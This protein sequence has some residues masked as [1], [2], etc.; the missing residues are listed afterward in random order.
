MRH[1]I[2][3]QA[4]KYHICRITTCC[5]FGIRIDQ[6]PVAAARDCPFCFAFVELGEDICRLF[7]DKRKT[8][9]M[10]EAADRLHV[11]LEEIAIAVG[12]CPRLYWLSAYCCD[13]I[14][15]SRPAEQA[16]PAA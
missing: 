10:R 16:Q 15:I 12:G 4:A 9:H 1:V 11:S 8:I 3:E 14:G 2:G 7:E 5:G 13:Q 6:E